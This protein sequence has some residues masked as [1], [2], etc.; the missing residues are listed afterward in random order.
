MSDYQLQILQQIQQN[1]ENNGR[2]SYEDYQ[3]RRAESATA[4]AQLMSDINYC[5]TELEEAQFQAFLNSL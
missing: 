4:Y 2:I 5:P 3:R 1:N